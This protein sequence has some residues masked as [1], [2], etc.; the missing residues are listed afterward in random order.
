MKRS[1]KR[2]R[3][4]KDYSTDTVNVLWK[5]NNLLLDLPDIKEND[6]PFVSVLTITKDRKNIFDLPIHVWTEY[7]YPIHKIEWVIIDDS[8]DDSLQSILPPDNRIKYFHLSNP[9]PIPDKRNFGVKKCKGE[10]IV[11]M[12]DDDYYFPDSI[13]AKIRVLLKY[14][15]HSCVYS[16]PIGV[17]NILKKSSTIVSTSG[18]DIPEA[19]MAFSKSFWKK[20][21]FGNGIKNKNGFQHSEWFNF[22]KGRRKSLIKIPFWFNCIV[23]NHR[24][25]TTQKTRDQKWNGEKS[26]KNFIDILDNIS[27][28]KITQIVN[29]QS[30]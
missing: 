21:K 20:G 28:E 18:P 26:S 4:K 3:I 30:L 22:V 9:L 13:L 16:N 14:K 12:D 10:Y 25:N 19:T 24:E 7:K 17:Y 1:V 27:R 23:L 5:N 2:K 6:F 29:K 8:K 11:L 15:E